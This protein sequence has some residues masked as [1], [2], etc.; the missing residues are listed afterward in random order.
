[1]RKITRGIYINGEKDDGETKMALFAYS[2]LHFTLA[3]LF[4]QGWGR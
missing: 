2:W 3:I 1:M 4:S